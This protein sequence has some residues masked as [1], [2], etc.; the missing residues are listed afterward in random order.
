[1]SYCTSEQHINKIS[2]PVFPTDGNCVDGSVQS[3]GSIYSNQSTRAIRESIKEQFET[4]FRRIM[5]NEASET[6]DEK[7]Q[8]LNCLIGKFLEGL[9]ETINNLEGTAN[10]SEQILQNER[11]FLESQTQIIKANENSDLVSMYRQESSTKRTKRDN[12]YFTVYV[13]VIVVF[14]ILEGIIFFV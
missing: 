12:T 7:H 1:M 3:P 4:E 2:V 13:S 14:L 9:H 10:S 5:N 8:L 6:D 11:E